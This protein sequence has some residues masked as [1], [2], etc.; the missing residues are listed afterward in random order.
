MLSM[1]CLFCTVF[2]RG[3]THHGAL[4]KSLCLIIIL[5]LPIFHQFA[6]IIKFSQE[7]IINVICLC[8]PFDFSH[9]IIVSI[10]W[11]HIFCVCVLQYICRILFIFCTTYSNIIIIVIGQFY[12]VCINLVNIIINCT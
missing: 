11:Y 1:Y 9:C 5:N 10:M 4:Y 8:G 3:I 12:T 7:T 6:H 2:Y